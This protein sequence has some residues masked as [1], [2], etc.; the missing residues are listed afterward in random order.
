MESNFNTL[1]KKY[2]KNMELKKEFILDTKQ[3]VSQ[4]I[5]D[6]FKPPINNFIFK[7]LDENDNNFLSFHFSM[8]NAIQ[9]N[10]F[11]VEIYDI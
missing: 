1:S 11:E 9:K 4:S 10:F 5:L 8:E 6:L 7:G 3:A 2:F